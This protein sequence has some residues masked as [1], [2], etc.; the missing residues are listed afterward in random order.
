MKSCMSTK[1]KKKTTLVTNH[2]DFFRFY[3]ENVEHA[4]H[5]AVQQHAMAVA[6]QLAQ[7]PILSIFVNLRR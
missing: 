6:L 5:L 4:G 1:K 3:L 2:V 7:Q